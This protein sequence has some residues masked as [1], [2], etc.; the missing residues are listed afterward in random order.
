MRTKVNREKLTRAAKLVEEKQIKDWD[1]KLKRHILVR[2]SAIEASA[3]QKIKVRYL[4][5]LVVTR[6]K[7]E[8]YVL[9]KIDRLVWQNKAVVGRVVLYLGRKSMPLLA[10][11]TKILDM[12]SKVLEDL[13]NQDEKNWDLE[14]EPD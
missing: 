6:G 11:V 12:S 10:E 9:T 8:A 4:E 1:F 2:N 14:E 7:E 5:P 13:K 3:D